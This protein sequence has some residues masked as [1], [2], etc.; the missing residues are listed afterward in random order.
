MVETFPF[1]GLVLHVV[2]DQLRCLV[3]RHRID[4]DWASIGRHVNRYITGVIVQEFFG[5]ALRFLSE[6][7]RTLSS[8]VGVF[9]SSLSSP[10]QQLF[11]TWIPSGDNEKKIV[12]SYNPS[13]YRVFRKHSKAMRKE[14]LQHFPTETSV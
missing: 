9:F 11:R 2:T 6:A 5:A 10:F 13:V 7:F 4:I 1:A 3:G 14:T 12:C 8:G